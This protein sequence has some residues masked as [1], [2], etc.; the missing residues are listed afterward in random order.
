MGRTKHLTTKLDKI[1]EE[2]GRHRLEAQELQTDVL[3]AHRL[4]G[5]VMVELTRFAELVTATV[6][7]AAAT[8]TED[9]LETFHERLERLTVQSMDDV[10]ARDKG[11]VQRPAVGT[12][13]EE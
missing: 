1:I 10:A 8:R 6:P 13:I 4:M 12:P 9:D 5:G 3:Q 2:V 11:D 7:I